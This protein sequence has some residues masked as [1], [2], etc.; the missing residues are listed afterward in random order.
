MEASGKRTIVYIE[1]DQ[2]MV[3]L[4][5][6]MLTRDNFEVIG[7]RE[8]QKGVETVR[9][10]KPALVLLDLML[11]DVG[12]WTVYQEIK[13]TPELCDIPVIV[14]TARGA[15]IDR[16][17]GEHIAKVQKYIVKPFSTQELRDSI[18]HVLS[19]EKN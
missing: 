11:P 12:G 2:D 7:V 13:Q 10:V 17:L 5:Q 1:D 9:Q 8:G 15:P 16:V 14:V 3:D 6:V 4:V 19:A 18:K